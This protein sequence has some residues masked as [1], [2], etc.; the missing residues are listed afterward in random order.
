MVS[1]ADV[2]QVDCSTVSMDG[3][4]PW[5]KATNLEEVTCK[6]FSRGMARE[7]QKVGGGDDFRCWAALRPANVLT[8]ALDSSLLSTGTEGTRGGRRV[9]R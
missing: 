3:K 9:L 1:A 6:L 5:I 7:M 2:T 8:S 4:N